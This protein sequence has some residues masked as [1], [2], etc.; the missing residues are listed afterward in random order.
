MGGLASVYTL[1]HTQRPTAMEFEWDPRKAESNLEKHRI[2]FE[3]AIGIFGGPVLEI[4]SDRDGEER[5]NAIGILNGR[6]IAVI[7]TPREGRY[8]IISARKAT[9][10]ERTTYHQAQPPR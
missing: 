7:Y 6:E 2:D 5:Y 4:R 3:D 10:N 8:R 9:K 1:E